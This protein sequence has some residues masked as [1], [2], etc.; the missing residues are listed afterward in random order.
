TP[1]W[2]STA[3]WSDSRES[4]PPCSRGGF[5]TRNFTIDIVTQFIQMFEHCS[6]R[7]RR[8]SD[9][10]MRLLGPTRP[11]SV[12]TRGDFVRITQ[13]L[14]RISV[15]TLLAAGSLSA[16]AAQELCVYDMLGAAGDLYNM[17]KDYV[18]AMQQ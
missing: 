17:A 8:R 9:A 12:S 2:T 15:A 16:Q 5:P 4:P 10:A 11:G 14:S 3:S 1:A 7:F 6:G 13:T 18:V